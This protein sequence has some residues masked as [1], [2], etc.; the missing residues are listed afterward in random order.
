LNAF[1][2]APVKLLPEEERSVEYIYE[3]D[4]GATDIYGV[5]VLIICY[6]HRVNL[7]E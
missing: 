4:L 3:I 1:L 5:G 6:Y 2:G 7:Y